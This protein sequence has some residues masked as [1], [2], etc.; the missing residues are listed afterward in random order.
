[1]P[2]V[3]LGAEGTTTNTHVV[4]LHSVCNL[5]GDR[6]ISPKPQESKFYLGVSRKRIRITTWAG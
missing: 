5:V 4:F 2:G 6:T 3:A 1:M